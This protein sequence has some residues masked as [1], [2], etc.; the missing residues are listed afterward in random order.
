M[1]V[2]RLAALVAALLLTACGSSGEPGGT[3]G[4][5]GS[6]SSA[7]VATATVTGP[8]TGG[9]HGHPLWDSWYDLSELGYVEEEYFISG[10]AKTY[11]ATTPAD[12]TTRIIVRRPADAAR[13]NGT[14]LL[15]WVNVTAQFE[16]AVD[17]LEAHQLFHRD[18]YA[19]VHVSAQAAGLCCL[20]ELTPKMWDPARYAPIS[21]PGDDYAFD[22]LS[23][24]AKA[25]RAP[26]GT[27]PMGGLKVQRIIAM[28]QSQSASRLYDYV[29][30]VQRDANVI[31]GF[32]IH[33]GGGR[34]YEPAPAVPV[35]QLFSEFEA[36]P[37]EP[38]HTANYR[39]WEIAGSAH[40]NFWVGYHQ[41]F[42][43]GLR[44]VGGIQRP[45]SADEQMHDTAANYGEQVHPLQLAC[46]VAGTQFP[47]RYLVS[48]AIHHLDRWIR[49]GVAPPQGARFE[50][51]NGALRKDP[52]GNA[53]GGI[54]LPMVDLPVARS[55][56]TLCGLGGVT[57]PLTTPELTQLYATHADYYCRT[58]EATQ[59]VVEQGFL[60][61]ADAEELLTRAM[62]ARNRWLVAGAQDC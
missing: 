57:V 49:T 20:P 52:Y 7:R 15:D 28:G 17:T 58:K 26:A 6:H 56:A 51:G 19:Y 31:D 18:G 27:A 9:L 47:M 32:L 38:S 33:S 44:A 60:L 23:Q 14:V 43:A 24:I 29:T 10:T 16:N 4:S 37:E 39:A 13:F 25:I 21:H 3:G 61:P 54:R 35:I 8:V 30:Q 40:Q 12:Y 22:M 59:A 34:V 62:G 41:V 1:S 42:G 46:I 55:N 53:L 50:F 48:S 45:A 36:S 2:F 5:G 11:P